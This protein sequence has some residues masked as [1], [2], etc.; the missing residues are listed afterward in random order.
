MKDKPCAL[1]SFFDVTSQI[2]ASSGELIY[3]YMLIMH[4]AMVLDYL[5]MDYIVGPTILLG[6]NSCYLCIL[7]WF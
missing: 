6:V 2:P 5:R 1:S 7:H 4:C 3:M